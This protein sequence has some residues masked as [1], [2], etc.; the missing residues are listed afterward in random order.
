M[1]LT[2]ERAEGPT[3]IENP[4]ICPRRIY[5]APMALSGKG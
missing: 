4:G 3:L 2:R 5:L 1:A